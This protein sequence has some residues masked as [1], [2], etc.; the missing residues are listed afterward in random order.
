LPFHSSIVVGI[1]VLLPYCG[2]YLGIT[3][4]MGIA[5]LGAFDRFFN[6]RR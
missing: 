3:Q 5:S 6:R 4:R 2:L 1:C